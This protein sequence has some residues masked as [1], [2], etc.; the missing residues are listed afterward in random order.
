MSLNYRTIYLENN[1][2]AVTV[3]EAPRVMK[4][5][6]LGIYIVAW[7]DTTFTAHISFDDPKCVNYIVLNTLKRGYEFKSYYV[8]WK[9]RCRKKC[10]FWEKK[11]KSYYVVWKRTIKD[12]Y[13]L[14]QNT[15]LNR[16]M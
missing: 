9:N 7:A 3:F 16:T 15:G 8:V 13:S 10:T 4:R 5:I 6:F 2:A 11:F 12:N 1:L 14:S